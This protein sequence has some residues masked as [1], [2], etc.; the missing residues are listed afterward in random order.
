MSIII[1]ILI[2]ISTHIPV[3]KLLAEEIHYVI[4]PAPA[5]SVLENNS[6]LIAGNPDFIVESK[7]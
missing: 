7:V 2:T 1:I 4:Q 3:Q 5:V 6:H